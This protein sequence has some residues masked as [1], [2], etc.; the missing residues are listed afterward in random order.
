MRMI[1]Y[2]IAA[3]AFAALAQAAARAEE[4]KEPEPFGRLTVDEAAQKLGKKGV[5]FFDNNPNELFAQGHV[6]GAKWVKY[7]AVTAGDLPSDKA[8]TLVF[9]C[10]NE[11]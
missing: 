11:H 10:A 3:I 6:P 4:A 2:C 7:D 5:Y 1:R 8:A 9:Y